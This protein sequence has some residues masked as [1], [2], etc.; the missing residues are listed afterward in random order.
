MQILKHT[1]TLKTHLHFFYALPSNRKTL[2]TLQFGTELSIYGKLSTTK[3]LS[4]LQLQA[5]LIYWIH[6]KEFLW[7]LELSANIYGDLLSD[8]CDFITL[9][10]LTGQTW[11]YLTRITNFLCYRMKEKAGRNRSSVNEYEKFAC[12]TVTYGFAAL[13]LL[14]AAKFIGFWSGT[15]FKE[16]PWRMLARKRENVIGKFRK[17]VCIFLYVLV[18]WYHG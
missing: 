9:E 7:L 1:S 8:F 11:P 3:R 18:G 12:N 15:N 6:L 10:L 13:V 4:K 2:L 17:S 14:C 16:A 5:W